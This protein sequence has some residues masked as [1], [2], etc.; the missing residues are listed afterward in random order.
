MFTARRSGLCVGR[1]FCIP[2]LVLLLAAL[3]LAAGSAQAGRYDLEIEKEVHLGPV[4]CA[5]VADPKLEGG[6]VPISFTLLRDDKDGDYHVRVTV[7]RDNSIVRLL[8]NSL[9]PAT[10][11]PV[12]LWWD[13]KDHLGRI[14]SPGEYRVMVQASRFGKL[15]TGGATVNIMRLGITEIEALPYQVDEEWQMVY[16]RKGNQYAFYATPAIHE[17]LNIAQDGEVSDLDLNSGEPRPAVPVHPGTAS[18]VLD[19]SGNYDTECYNYPLCYLMNSRPRFK[20]TMGDTCTMANGRSGW[21]GYPVNG[22][23][24]RCL[25]ED[26]AGIWESDPQGIRPGE[27][28]LFDGPAL[29]DMACRT[30][31]TITWR[32]QYRVFGEGAWMD[33]PGVFETSHRFYTI[34]DQPYW[35]SGASGTQYAGPW[36]EVA[37]YLCTYADVLK[38]NTADEART[39]KAF[40]RGYF[41]QEGPLATAIEG[42]VYDCYSMGGDG[43]ATHYYSFYDEYIQLSRLLNSHANGVF[44]NCSDVS[45]SSSVMLGM[46]G[47]QNVRMVYLGNMSLRAIW[48]IGC[49]EYTLNLWGSG[50]GFSYHH[51]VT[52]DG[53]VHVSD[54]CMWLDED[55]D[56]DALP[57]IPGYN[58]DRPWSG[59]DGYNEL[60]AS[61]NVSLT[62]D[63]L[64]DIQ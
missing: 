57:G 23:Q 17:Y 43:G 10:G 53:G 6:G 21:C 36:V 2:C 34:V 61:N 1:G 55:G 5:R 42:V 15:F 4:H 11:R 56:P 19:G 46:L 13:G 48:G 54:A 27:S 18:P 25:A 30:D 52:R 29:P 24:V 20:V 16:F 58:T 60:S 31:R 50:H 39:L 44:L 9:M 37:D 38:I 35:P 40:I 47:V 7:I 45:S 28:Y 41:G 33:I 8:E 32:W 3:F 22:V 62:L 12:D 51:I 26:Q 49:P 14:V 59:P 63:S 64:P